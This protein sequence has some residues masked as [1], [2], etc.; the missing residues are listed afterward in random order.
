M[1]QLQILLNQ[2]QT[3]HES[4]NRVT[5]KR[6]RMETNLNLAAHSSYM[7]RQI[8]ASTG[9]DYKHLFSKYQNYHR[10]VNN[11]REQIIYCQQDIV[12]ATA[13]L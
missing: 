2:L 4:L 8:E 10:L 11:I 12:N 6:D 9:I 13:D 1:E 3:L 7:Q 5:N